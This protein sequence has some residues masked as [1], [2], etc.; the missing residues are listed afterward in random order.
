MSAS[1]DVRAVEELGRDLV[2][3]PK[4]KPHFADR[5]PNCDSAESPWRSGDGTKKGFSD[6]CRAAGTVSQI[7]G[8]SGNA[9]P[10]PLV[11]AVIYT[12]PGGLGLRKG[13]RPA[14]L[15]KF[16]LVTRMCSRQS[17]QA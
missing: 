2:W 5:S 12:A 9:E 4:R 10:V 11:R 14:S 13:E 17:V 8:P 16:S 15:L 3:T 6:G 1:S 7:L